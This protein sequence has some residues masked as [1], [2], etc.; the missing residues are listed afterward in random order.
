MHTDTQTHRAY[1]DLQVPPFNL[2]VNVGNDSYVTVISLTY[3]TD[4]PDIVAHIECCI[5]TALVVKLWI[6]FKILV[7]K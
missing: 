2:M 3:P 5:K 6:F 7:K 4:E 1:K